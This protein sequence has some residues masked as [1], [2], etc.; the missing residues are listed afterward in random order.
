MCNDKVAGVV[1]WGNGCARKGFPGVYTDV[2]AHR[3]WMDAVI[4]GGSVSELNR[5]ISCVMIFMA[6]IGRLLLSVR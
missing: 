2:S 6:I 5:N 1:S 3:A 4:N